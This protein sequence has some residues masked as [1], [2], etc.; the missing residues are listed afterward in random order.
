MG[1]CLPTGPY[2]VI[3]LMSLTESI[4]VD[5]VLLVI[6]VYNMISLDDVDT[7][8]SKNMGQTQEER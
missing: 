6:M 7:I 1:S 5:C 3:P 8:E 4:E 2:R